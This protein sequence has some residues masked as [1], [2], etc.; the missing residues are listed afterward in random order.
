MFLPDSFEVTT[1]SDRE[2]LVTRDF[3]A[4]RRQVF[5]AF[6]KP[7]LVRRWLLG[8]PG[9]T[10]PLCEIDLRVGGA[11][12]YVWRSE[13]DGTTMAMGGVFREV[14]VPE[15][16]VATERFDDAWYPGEALDTTVFVETCGITR[17]TITVLYESQ[18]ARDTARRSGM[19]RGMAAGY[20]RLEAL[21]PTFI[22][23][24]T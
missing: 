23:G 20:D 1:P 24:R 11:Y 12:R 21:L 10:M 19:E 6:T 8:P 22:G 3:D 16:L 18:D 14:V 5:D 7:E 4:P 2:I 15:R 9:W 13:K 17:T